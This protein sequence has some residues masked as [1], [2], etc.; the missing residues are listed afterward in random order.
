MLD[1]LPDPKFQIGETV[2]WAKVDTHGYGRIV[3]LVFSSGVSVQAFGFHYLV[4]FAAES[5]SQND[6]IADWGFEDDLERLETHA[7]LPT[8]LQS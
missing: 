2:V 7:H 6:C 4:L 8:N 1:C 3:G 5:P